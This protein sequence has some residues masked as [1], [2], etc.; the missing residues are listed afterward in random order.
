MEYLEM[1]AI[2]VIVIVV[3]KFVLK[4][5]GNMIKGFI[6]NALVGCALMWALS[7]FH[8]IA[9]PIN[10]ITAAVAGVFGIP[11]VIVLAILV[12]LHIL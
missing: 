2:A 10:W 9:I 3:A 1:I 5:S 7:Y 11:G 4:L 12:L 6:I 8:I